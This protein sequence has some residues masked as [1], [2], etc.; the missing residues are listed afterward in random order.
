M[1][2]RKGVDKNIADSI[3][4]TA[5]VLIFLRDIFLNYTMPALK[6]YLVQFDW[7]ML[8]A[9]ES[10]LVF[11][12]HVTKLHISMY[13]ILIHC[14]I[15]RLKLQQ[16]LYKFVVIFRKACV[17]KVFLQ[18]ISN[19][20]FNIHDENLKSIFIVKMGYYVLPVLNFCQIYFTL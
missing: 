14:I 3:F 8:P 6:F 18:F 4:F 11:H 5:I 12:L 20:C 17:C 13:K 10:N 15:S 9:I 19:W 2:D 16:G 1:L 7:R